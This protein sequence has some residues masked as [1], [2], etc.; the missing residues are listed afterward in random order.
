MVILLALAVFLFALLVFFA[1]RALIALRATLERAD[2]TLMELNRKMH[3]VDPILRTLSNLGEVSEQKT[4]YLKNEFVETSNSQ[5][6]N[7][8]NQIAEWILLSVLLGKK[9][10]KRR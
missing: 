8:S 4:Q 5:N 7:L 2:D 10:L 6:D 1:I 9:I 3:Y